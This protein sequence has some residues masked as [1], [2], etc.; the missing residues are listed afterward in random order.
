MRELDEFDWARDQTC[1][2]LFDTNQV[3]IAKLFASVHQLPLHHDKWKNWDSFLAIHHANRL[4]EKGENVLDAGACR[5]PGS[6]S[7]FLPSLKKLGFTNLTGCNLDETATV[8]EDGI[9][10]EHGDIEKTGYPNNCFSYVTCLSTIEHGVDWRKY[11]QEMARIIRPKGFLF[12][13][14]DYWQNPVD[15]KGQRAFGVPIKIFTE[16]EV[17]QM[18]IYAKTCGLSLMKRPIFTCKERVVEW[19]GMSYTFMNLL[20]RKDTEDE[21]PLVQS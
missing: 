15:T 9:L 4:V 13:S 7:A 10:Y 12:T 21:A 14:F 17:M 20:M 19:M 11:F 8:T 5:D 3:N 2:A 1:S 16:L 6:P 18:A